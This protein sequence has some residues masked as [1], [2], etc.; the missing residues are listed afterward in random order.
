MGGNCGFFHL[1]LQHQVL[2]TGLDSAYAMPRR[3]QMPNY[4]HCQDSQ[5]GP[6]CV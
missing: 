2:A 6:S 5:R 4:P 1:L 3:H